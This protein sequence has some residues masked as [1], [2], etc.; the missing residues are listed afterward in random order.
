M[1]SRFEMESTSTVRSATAGRVIG[2]SCF[3]P[4]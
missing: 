3:V 2:L 4:S 1:F